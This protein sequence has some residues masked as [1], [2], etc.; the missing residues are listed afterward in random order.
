MSIELEKEIDEKLWDAIRPSYVS[1]NYTNSILDAITFL[2][3]K[4]KDISS[5]NIDGY[6]LV[7]KIIN[8]KR[9]RINIPSIEEDTEKATYNGLKNILNGL[10][11]YYRNTR[12]HNTALYK[13]I[14]TQKDVDAIILFINHLIPHVNDS[15][16]V[17][18]KEKLFKTITNST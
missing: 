7:E 11:Q 4:L 16:P 9:L 13:L 17:F 18:T 14:D 12:S 3:T 10:Y 2:Y 1:K 8:P 5:E 6:D 15:K